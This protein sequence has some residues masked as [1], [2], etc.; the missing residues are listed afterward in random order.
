MPCVRGAFEVLGGSAA[1]RNFDFHGCGTGGFGGRARS[2]LDCAAPAAPESGKASVSLAPDAG[3]PAAPEG[4]GTVF[5]LLLGRGDV[6]RIREGPASGCCSLSFPRA[7]PDPFLSPTVS[8]AFPFSL[9]VG[10]SFAKK[11]LSAFC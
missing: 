1:A 9:L 11:T 8:F 3:V 4:C 7:G 5:A 10:S 2:A 6:A